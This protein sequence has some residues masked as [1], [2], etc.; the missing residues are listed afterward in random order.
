MGGADAALLAA[1]WVPDE[2]IDPFFEAAAQAVEEAI[3]NAIVANADMEG[4]DGNFVP[5]IPHE[6]L[7][8]VV[9]V[10]G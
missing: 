5:A 2:Q 6:R 9:G 7:R 10:A 4:R 8:K 3:L 1:T